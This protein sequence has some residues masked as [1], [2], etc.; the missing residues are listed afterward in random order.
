M[1]EMAAR[2]T[3]KRPDKEETI[4]LVHCREPRAIRFADDGETPNNPQL[5][6]LL[7]RRAVNLPKEDDPAAVFENLFLIH[8]WRMA[9]RDGVYSFLHFH[10]R[11]HEVLGIARGNACVRFGGK[12][13]QNITVKAGDVVV[14]PAGTGHRRLA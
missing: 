7:Y 12:R 1:P 2:K 4:R 6:L 14:L 10:T 5:P 9:W 8:G 3:K 13:G 11:T